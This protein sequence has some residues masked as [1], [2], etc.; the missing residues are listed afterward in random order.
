MSAPVVLSD[1]DAKRLERALRW[2]ERNM[3]N[4]QP[5][6]R[7]RSPAV[8]GGGG[9]SATLPRLAY[10]KEGATA[11]NYILCFLDFYAVDEY[12]GGTTYDLNDTVI[13]D[14]IGYRSLQDDNTG[15][16]PASSPEWWE[17]LT[18]ITVYCLI[19]GTTFLDQAS[20]RLSAGDPM[21]VQKINNT[22]YS[23]KFQKTKV[24]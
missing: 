15:N 9:G 10:C 1:R 6:M 18:E 4:L 2:F 13:D 22:W 21:I 12:A 24:C 7:R 5:Q 23:D 17:P 8:G 19:S 16:T 20:P 14:D 11:A 3:H